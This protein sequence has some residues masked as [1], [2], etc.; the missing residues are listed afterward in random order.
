[1]RIL[2]VISEAPPIQSGIARVADKL[3]RGLNGRGHQVDI[4]SLQDVPRV[5]RGEIRLSSMPFR[6]SDLRDRFRSYDVIHLHGPVPTFSD[7]FLLWGLH[8]LNLHRPKLVYTHHAPIDLHNFLFPAAWLYNRVQERMAS[9]AD[10]V[11]ATTPSYGQ[12]LSRHVPPHK[13]SVIPWG[14]DYEHFAAPVRKD[15]PFT[16]VYLGQIRP[17]K[18]LP[19]LLNAAA[20]VQDMRVWVI[21]NGHY[22]QE[23][24]QKAEA[25]GLRGVTFWGALPDEKMVALLKQAH[26]IVLPSVTRSEAFGIALLEGMAA[27]CVP[28][29]SYLP[30]VADIVGNEGFTFPA[31][32]TRALAE[33]LTRLRDDVPLRI[34]LAS[35]AQAKARLYSWDRTVFN[36]ERVYNR[37]ITAARSVSMRT[38]LPAD[39][40]QPAMKHRA[41]Q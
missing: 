18:G 28:V 31:G 23:S 25:L 5:E 1:M 32:N 12:T 21:G 14:V 40:T 13:L 16:V 34:H 10:H 15:G 27:G 7:V 33:V 9:L 30:G 37:V 19:V 35:V 36:Y 6:L 22:A 39:V 17:Y 4:L 38:R 24:R 41:I 2:L 8:G 11:V 29:A 3:S 20:G 26:A